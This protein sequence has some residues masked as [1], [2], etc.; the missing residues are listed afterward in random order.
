MNGGSGVSIGGVR[1]LRALFSIFGAA[2]VALW[3][4]PSKMGIPSPNP[5]KTGFGSRLTQGRHR[6]WTDHWL[7]KTL[8]VPP[9]TQTLGGSSDV[10]FPTTQNPSAPKKLRKTCNYIQ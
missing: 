6:R 8:G 5:A 4:H 10:T 1:S 3:E 9:G 2:C 7:L